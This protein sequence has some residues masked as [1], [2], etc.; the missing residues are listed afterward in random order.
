MKRKNSKNFEAFFGSSLAVFALFEQKVEVGA[1]I[2]AGVGRS[3]SVDVDEVPNGEGAENDAKERREQAEPL[4]E[5]NFPRLAIHFRTFNL[6]NFQIF[7][8]S[9]FSFSIFN[10]H[11]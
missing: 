1:E 3:A 8:F 5:S 2:G 6:K 10:F 9:L 7:R 4:R 11:R